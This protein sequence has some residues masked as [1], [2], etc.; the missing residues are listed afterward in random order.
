MSDSVRSYLVDELTPLVNQGWRIIRE[1]RM[2]ETIDTITVVL[3]HSRIEKLPEAPMGALR[4]EV[5][6][7]VADPHEDI[8]K[9]EDALDDA[10][11]DLLSVI[12]KH[13]SINWTEARKA[14][15]NDN[16]LGWDI[17]LTVITTATS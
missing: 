10:V 4:N 5:V 6:L 2:P 16:I 7:T 11:V 9:A 17:T 1:Q 15:V 14:K 12:D 8:A 3:K 13:D